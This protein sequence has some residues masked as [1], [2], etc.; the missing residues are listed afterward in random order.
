MAT[1]TRA[2]ARVG[3]FKYL[4]DG[5][6]EYLFDLAVDPGEKT[7]LKT[8]DPPRFAALKSRYEAWAAEMLPRP[9]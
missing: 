8:Y 4:Q 3:R 6:A 5:N 1:C 9:S 7:D 2:A